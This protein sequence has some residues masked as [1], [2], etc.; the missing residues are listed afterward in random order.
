MVIENDGS[1]MVDRL[2][3]FKV[4]WDGG[5]GDMHD[6]FE[7]GVRV[8][9]T[10]RAVVESML[11]SQYGKDIM[12]DLFRRYARLVGDYLATSKTK[13]INLVVSLVKKDFRAEEINREYI[14]DKTNENGNHLFYDKVYS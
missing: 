3:A 7:R 13:Y 11:Q 6:P 1:F 12:D 2:E 10:I 8:A 4:E 14:G 9:N 5:C